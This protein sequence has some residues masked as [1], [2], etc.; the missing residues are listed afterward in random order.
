MGKLVREPLSAFVLIAV[1]VFALDAWRSG[2]LPE[3]AADLGA[4]R[5]APSLD[6]I[7]VTDDLVADLQEDFAWLA[8]R[9][10]T[11]QETDSIVDEWL[12]E[13]IV[14]R[15]ALSRQMHLSDGRVRASLIEKMRLLWAGVPEYP[16]EGEMLEYYVDHMTR[17][18]SEVRV[19]F[20]QIFFERSPEQ[21]E[22]LLA[23]LRAGEAVTG[24]PYWLG[25]T[26]TDYAASILR[27]SFGGAFLNELLAA[28]LNQW[29]GP[30]PSPRGHHFVYVTSRQ[31]PRPLAYEDVRERLVNDWVDARHFRQIEEQTERVRRRFSVVFESGDVPGR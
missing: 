13:E 21:P 23:R 2:S 7:L 20:E 15:E 24:D 1:A 6:R 18:Y 29:T 17:Y 16:T 25:E 3:E 12:E 11:P 27:T 22:A 10:P 31:E 30:L 28:P 4:P 8:G 14:F 26:L 19:S 5:N 9:Q